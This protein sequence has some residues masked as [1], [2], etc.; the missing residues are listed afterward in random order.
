M[1]LRLELELIPATCWGHNLRTILPRR[2]W[3]IIQ[4]RVWKAQR[5][6]CAGCGIR[7]PKLE[8]HEVWKYDDESHIQK[9]VHVEGLC[10]QCHAVK[11][12]GLA[13]FRNKE[14][15]AYDHFVT[16]NRIEIAHANLYIAEARR[17]WEERCFWQWTMDISWLK[18]QNIP[19][20][21]EYE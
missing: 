1:S 4:Q 6:E 20:P 3:E 12:Y 8:C 10:N 15:E 13:C 16:V 5:F 11:H 7:P 21:E 18:S 2:D 17:E 14:R 19:I 9:L